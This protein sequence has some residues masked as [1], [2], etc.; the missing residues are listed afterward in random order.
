[1]P[2]R[3]KSH[4]GVRRHRNYTVDDAALA[5]GVARGTVRRWLKNGGLPAI[6]DRR[7]YLILG[8]DLA[9]YL[10]DRKA[11]RQ[12]CQLVECFCFACRAPRAPA[13]RMVELD[14]VTATTG[15]MKA[16]CETCLGIMHKRLSLR[17][18]PDLKSL[19]DVTIVQA[20]PHITECA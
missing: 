19:V 7:P 10:T 5:S 15:N 8:E 1:M 9:A 3:A 2:R 6:T 4:R 16:L 17:K 13:G 18:L 11:P 14:H 20:A 12:R